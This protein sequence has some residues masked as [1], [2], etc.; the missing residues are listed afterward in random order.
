MSTIPGVYA[1][2]TVV[3]NTPRGVAPAV[4]CL[5]G[6]AD[7]GRVMIPYTFT[8]YTQAVSTLGSTTAYGNLIKMISYNFLNGASSVKA[9]VAAATGAASDLAYQQALAVALKEDGID[10]V[11]IEGTSAT[12][13]GYLKTHLQ[14]SVTENKPRRGYAGQANSAAISTY[15]S[16]AG[17]LA[18]DRQFLV[19]P[20]FLDNTGVALSG[21]VTAAAVAAACEGIS[22]PAVPRTGL[23]IAGVSGIE[24]KLLTSDYDTLHGGGVLTT[25]SKDGDNG[26]MRY[27]TTYTGTT[28][29]KEGTIALER[30]YVQNKLVNGVTPEFRQSKMTSKT[31]AQIKASIYSKMRDLQTKEIVNPDYP[32][33]VI[34]TQDT[35]DLS[36]ANAEVSYYS[37]YPLNF[38]E[39]K[40]IL[41]I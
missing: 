30:D 13:L 21:G 40:L 26:I 5:I 22:D 27:L 7:G 28:G 31:M 11:V 10:Y 12:A 38:I 37:V 16:T 32:V 25:K 23:P 14:A 2:T 41:N 24:T 3:A 20:N 29:I 17:T 8:T 33:Q 18:N 34:V 35:V 9:I 1:S 19:G 4:G 36:K 39:L 15:V 6:A